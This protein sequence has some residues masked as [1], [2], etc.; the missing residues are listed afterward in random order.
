MKPLDIGWAD[1]PLVQRHSDYLGDTLAMRLSPRVPIEGLI[2]N[3]TDDCSVEGFAATF[4]VDV[5]EV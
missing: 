3:Y 4:E 2:A 1:C 5:E